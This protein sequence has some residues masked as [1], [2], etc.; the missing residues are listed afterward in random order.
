M[1]S[2]V[3]AARDASSTFHS[4]VR[5]PLEPPASERWGLDLAGEPLGQ[6]RV[7]RID[8]GFDL[9]KPFEQVPILIDI[10]KVGWQCAEKRGGG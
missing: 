10:V 1:V 8:L 2:P 7:A 5:Y 4:R 6:A 3:S 9:G